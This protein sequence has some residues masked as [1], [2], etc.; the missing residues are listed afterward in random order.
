VPIYHPTTTLALVA[1][2]EGG[3]GRP[4]VL[5]KLLYRI[6]NLLVI[7][8][9]W[10]GGA[11]P[12]WTG[13][14]TRG[15][16]ARRSQFRGSTACEGLTEAYTAAA[17]PNLERR[18]L[19]RALPLSAPARRREQEKTLRLRSDARDERSGLRLCAGARLS[20]AEG[21]AQRPAPFT[22]ANS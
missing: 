22:A 12:G 13:R 15:R 16:N 14:S 2:T 8:A 19:S 9:K 1:F 3:R 21:A 20:G 5:G 7:S 10:A 11:G 6:S 17:W 18:R 4:E